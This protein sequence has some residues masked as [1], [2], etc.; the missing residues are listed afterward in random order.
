MYSTTVPFMLISL[1]DQVAVPWCARTDVPN[2]PNAARATSTA[3]IA[4]RPN[5]VH[6]LF[7]D[8]HYFFSFSAGAMFRLLKSIESEGMQR[9]SPNSVFGMSVICLTVVQGAV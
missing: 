9:C 7:S 8:C 1:S 2:L 3:V 5:I 4:I 6:L